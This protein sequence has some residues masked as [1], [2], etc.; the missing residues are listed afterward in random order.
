VTFVERSFATGR[1]FEEESSPA[2]RRFSFQIE[3]V[4]ARPAP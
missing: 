3:P 2:D 1:S 4:P